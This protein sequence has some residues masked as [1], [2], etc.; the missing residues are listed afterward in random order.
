[1]RPRATSPRRCTA[2]SNQICKHW[3]TSRRGSRPQ[4]RPQ[5]ACA[6]HRYAP[7]RKRHPRRWRRGL[8]SREDRTGDQHRGVREPSE[9]AE[10][11]VVEAASR[12]SQHRLKVLAGEVSSVIEKMLATTSLVGPARLT[13][14]LFAC[15]PGALPLA[16]ATVGD[17]RRMVI[18]ENAGPF[19]VARRVL[20]EMQSRPTTS[21]PT[22]VGGASSQRSGTSRRSSAGRS[23][24][25]RW[26][27]RR[28]QEHSGE[29]DQNEV[30]HMVTPDVRGQVD[31]LLKSG[32][33][34]PEEILGP[35]ELR[36]AWSRR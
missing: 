26:R 15:Q 30:L 12:R 1:M 22:A 21:S 33:R 9:L 14:E 23:H 27:S 20:V 24:P 36:R 34:I 10:Q 29:T 16:W 19:A 35:D 13:F 4:S 8:R 32:R 3:R 31:A 18:F 7:A 11:R 25:L 6:R 2:S 17:G 5:R 28:C